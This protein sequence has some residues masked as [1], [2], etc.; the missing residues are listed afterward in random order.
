MAAAAPASGAGG[1]SRS[2]RAVPCRPAAVVAGRGR[3][4]GEWVAAA[5]WIAIAPSARR[6]R[7]RGPPP[8]A[9][10]AGGDAYQPSA[11]D[12]TA[13]KACS[14]GWDA[15]GTYRRGHHDAGGRYRRHDPTGP[16]WPAPADAPPSLAESREYRRHVRVG[17]W[18][19]R[20]ARDESRWWRFVREA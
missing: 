5:S 9:A 3:Q 18:G 6:A 7:N 13:V 15:A 12:G 10:A 17:E 1:R 14:A 11:A 4:A 16:A 8:R 19:C 20:I 2:R